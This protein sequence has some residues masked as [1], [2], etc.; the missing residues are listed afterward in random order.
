MHWYLVGVAA[1]LWVLVAVSGV[2]AIRTGR[3]LPPW[4]GRRVLR[5][6]LWGAGAIVMALGMAVPS[7]YPVAHSD[8]AIDAVFVVGTGLFLGGMACQML[9][10]RQGHDRTEPAA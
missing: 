3:V 2:V 1:A 9:A 4:V 10:Q 6:R 5:P 8:M 7:L